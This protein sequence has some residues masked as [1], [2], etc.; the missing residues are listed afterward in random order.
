[1]LTVWVTPGLLASTSNS[2]AAPGAPF[3]APVG[4]TGTSTWSYRIVAKLGDG[5][6]TQGSTT[7]STASGDDNL[8]TSN[9]NNLSWTPVLGVVS[10][11]VIALPWEFLLAPPARSPT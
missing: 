9:F 6:G 1:M 8:D 10:Y 4:A 5:S 11:D 2:L 7:G 3:V